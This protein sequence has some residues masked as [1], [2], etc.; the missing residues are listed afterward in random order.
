MRE[1]RIGGEDRQIMPEGRGA[2]NHID[3]SP[4]NTA[5]AAE[6]EEPRRLVEISRHDFQ[7]PEVY[8]EFLQGH[9]D[10]F[11]A[12]SREDLLPNGPYEDDAVRQS[13]FFP[14]RHQNPLLV[15]ELIRPPP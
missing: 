13:Q 2:N 4:D 10:V 1:I 15:G 5:R 11:F 9:E 14:L 6:V 12:D 3:G 7:G 8:E